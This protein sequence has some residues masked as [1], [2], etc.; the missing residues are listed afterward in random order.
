MKII[1]VDDQNIKEFVELSHLLF[2]E[3]TYDE[4]LDIYSKA[5]TSD[6]EMC[7]IY[8]VDDKAAGMLHLSIRSDY[9]NGTST[10]PV[11]YIEGIYVLQEYRKHGVG[12]KFL[13]FAESI[14]KEKGIKQLASDCFIDNIASERFHKSCGFREEERVICFVKDVD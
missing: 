4:L 8:Q 11:V 12:R 3:E 1:T 2:P 9:V 7:Y 10:S 5:I 14:A 6:K 13:D